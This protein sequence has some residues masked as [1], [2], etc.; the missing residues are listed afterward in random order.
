MLAAH[1]RTWHALR[2]TKTDGVAYVILDGKLFCCDGLGEKATSVKG[3][4][5]DRWY[6]GEHHGQDG[7]IQAVTTPDGFP[8]WASPVEPGSV[9]D[10]TAAE[11][12]TLGALYWAASQL[13]L[14]TLADGGYQGTATECTPG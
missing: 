10:I 2:Q 14:P 7:N 9:H 12:H 1:A 6:S 8:I 4:T 13:D 11:H 5:F 3:T